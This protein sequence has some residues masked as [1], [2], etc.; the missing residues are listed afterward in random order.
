MDPESSVELVRRA[1]GGDNDA[2]NQLIERYRPRL[3]RWAAGR[4]PRHARDFADTEDLVQ[5]AL[6]GTFRN[7]QHFEQRGEWALQAY[8]RRAVLN[9][10]R[11]ELRRFGTQPRRQALPDR[12]ASHGQS[13]LEAAVGGEFFARYEAA[14]AVLSE[15]EREAV[16]ARIE[17]G[18]TYEEIALLVDKPT[19]DAARMCVTRAL[20]RLALVMSTG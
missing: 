14:L 8:L 20:D 16:I 5:E 7:F 3:R 1:Q 4:L 12:T 6:L 10:V 11:D 15:I 19:P 9:R 18:C 2:L 17:L 13:P